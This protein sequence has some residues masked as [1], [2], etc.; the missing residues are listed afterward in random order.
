MKQ[1]WRIIFWIMALCVI[2]IPACSFA[3]GDHLNNEDELIGSA[4]SEKDEMDALFTE[5]ESD[6]ILDQNKEDTMSILEVKSAQEEAFLASKPSVNMSGSAT[7]SKN[8]NIDGFLGELDNPMRPIPKKDSYTGTVSKDRN[9]RGS[10]AR[11]WE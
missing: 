7:F 11:W 6:E 8:Q 3:S 4:S 1:N 2:I 5:S 9:T 10:S